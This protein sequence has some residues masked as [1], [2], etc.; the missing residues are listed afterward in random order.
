MTGH[1]DHVMTILVVTNIGEG[2]VIATTTCLVVIDGA[3]V[4]K[5]VAG[6]SD[7]GIDI[8]AGL[9]GNHREVR[10]ITKHIIPDNVGFQ[11]SVDVG[12]HQVI[13]GCRIEQEV[14][15]AWWGHKLRQFWSLAA[16]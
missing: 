8:K 2:G 9:V 10:L 15:R 1:V 7:V 6:G 16:I 4:I 11:I 12:S 5:R 14:C 13:V 3:A